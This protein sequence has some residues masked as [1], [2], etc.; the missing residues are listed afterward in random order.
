MTEEAMVLEQAIQV[1]LAQWKAA[2]DI[3]VQQGF[4]LRQE[5]ERATLALAMLEA[6]YLEKAAALEAEIKAKAVRLG[7][8]VQG[9]GAEVKYTDGYTRYTWPDKALEGF[10][11]SLPEGLAGRMKTLRKATEVAPAVKVKHL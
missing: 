6:L 8:S 10:A 4:A 3:R 1:L 2:D 5:L 7:R 11:A 9:A